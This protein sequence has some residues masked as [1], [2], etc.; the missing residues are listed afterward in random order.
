M[1][2]LALHGL[3]SLQDVQDLSDE[4]R[5]AY[6]RWARRSCALAAPMIGAA[7]DDIVQAVLRAEMP[8]TV[9]AEIGA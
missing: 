3:R 5:K 9:I 6:R 4:D 7:S 8:Q 1:T 2:R